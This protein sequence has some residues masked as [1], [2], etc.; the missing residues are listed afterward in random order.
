MPSMTAIFKKHPGGLRG[1]LCRVLCARED[2][3]LRFADEL[4]SLEAR[5]QQAQDQLESLN[6]EIGELSQYLREHQSDRVEWGDLR[7]TRPISPEWGSDR[8]QPI[9]RFYIRQFLQEHSADIRGRILEVQED[10][11]ARLV[12]ERGVEQVDVLDL[13]AA[14]PRA[15]IVA[16]LRHAPGLESNTYDCIILTQTLHVIDDMAGVVNE[17]HRILRPQGVLL[18]TIPCLSRVCLEY[19]RDGDFWRMTEAGAQWLLSR[20]FPPSRVQTHACGNVLTQTAF[21]YGLASHEIETEE[22]LETD[23][24]HPLLITVRAQKAQPD[25]QAVIAPGREDGRGLILTYHSIS[26]AVPDPHG[27]VLDPELFRAQMDLLCEAYHPIALDTLVEAARQSHIPTRSVALTFDDGYQDALEIAA[28]I[29]RERDLPGDL[30]HQQ[31]GPR[32]PHGVLVGYPGADLLDRAFAPRP[33]QHRAA[34]VQHDLPCRSPAELEAAY[35]TIYKILATCPPAVRDDIMRRLVAWS[36]CSRVPL[37]VP[38]VTAQ[39]QALAGY[40][41]GHALGAHSVHHLAMGHQ[42]S[43]IQRQEILECRSQ[44]ERLGLAVNTFA[45][46]FGDLDEESV[47]L[48]RSA[49][50][51]CAVTGEERAVGPREDPFRLPRLTIKPGPLEEFSK[52]LEELH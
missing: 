11:Y 2:L 43:E 9:D 42:P 36:G 8:G 12:G 14:N 5:R 7:R 37:R 6:A 21:L 32:G 22:F 28:P 47:E 26:T 33:A 31:C 50:F 48:V 38:M 20:T 1:E 29:L 16:D 41:P 3:L 30:L 40:S 23:P 49:G 44:L 13:N 46:P 25:T 45:Y 19:G 24:Y 35:S 4:P 18:L 27:M 52:L 15:T 39:V 10:V 17:C 51:S 34:R